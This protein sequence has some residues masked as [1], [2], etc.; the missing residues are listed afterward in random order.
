V[1]T[2]LGRVVLVASDEG[3]TKLQYSD[4]RVDDNGVGRSHLNA[5]E[6]WLSAYFEADSTAESAT[7]AANQ[8]TLDLSNLSE[9]ASDVSLALVREVPF[10]EVF[11]YLELAIA[12]HRLGASRAVGRVMANNPWTLLVPCHRVV[13]SD[14]FIGNYSALNGS[15]TKRW[16]LSHEGRKFD[17]A[18]CLIR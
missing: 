4:G 14:G 1:E 10:G 16:L 6:A 8:P 5:G 17:S 11:S 2:P 13:R 3:L 15:E 18:G 7:I 12:A 9:F